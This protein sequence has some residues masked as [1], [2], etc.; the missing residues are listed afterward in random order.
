MARYHCDKVAEHL[1]T[2]EGVQVKA[3]T[4]SSWTFARHTAKATIRILPGCC[5]ILLIHNIS[6]EKR[7]PLQLI[8]YAVV[9]AK[10]AD[11]GLV[12]LS[13]KTE[14]AL[15]KLLGAEWQATKFT[16]PRTTNEVELFTQILP[17]KPKAK[18]PQRYNHEDE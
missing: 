10:R 7:D 2:I 9:A 11:F 4:S 5:G 15:R 3:I 13:L 18:K 12:L 16:N 14:S 6:G 1:Q 8:N 17:Y